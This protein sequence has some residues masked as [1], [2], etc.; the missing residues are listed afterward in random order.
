MVKQ[1]YAG[2]PRWTAAPEPAPCPTASTR[3]A[4]VAV[5]AQTGLRKACC[6]NEITKHGGKGEWQT[7]VQSLPFKPAHQRS[8]E[9]RVSAFR[10]RIDRGM[11]SC[12]SKRKVVSGG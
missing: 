12:C 9:L 2:Q 7:S 5:P 6:T 4:A 10:E 11:C 3:D 8:F 1:R